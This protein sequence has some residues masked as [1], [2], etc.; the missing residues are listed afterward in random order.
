MQL[1]GPVVS[2]HIGE[3]PESWIDQ[4]HKWKAAAFARF[5]VSYLCIFRHEDGPLSETDP[6]ELAPA[7]C[8]R[9]LGVPTGAIGLCLD[10]VRTLPSFF[11]HQPFCAGCLREL[12]RAVR[13]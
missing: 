3:S 13:E 5:D 9:M 11:E 10:V 1:R 8:G 7:L 2:D 4:F 12:S 6:T